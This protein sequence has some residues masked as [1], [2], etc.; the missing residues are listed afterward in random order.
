MPI[1]LTIY[2]TD[3]IGVGVSDFCEISKQSLNPEEIVLKGKYILEK[4]LSVDPGFAYS[5]SRDNNNDVTGIVRTISHMR[6]NFEH[7]GT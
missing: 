7:C 6:D 2:V 3:I 1:I 4:L 5:I